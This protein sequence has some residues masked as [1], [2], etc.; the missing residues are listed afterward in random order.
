MLSVK[1]NRRQITD[2]FK[3]VGV[4]VGDLVA[5]QVIIFELSVKCWRIRVA[6]GDRVA[7]QV[8]IFKLSVKCWRIRVAVGDRVA[9]QVIIFELSVKYRRNYAVGINVDDCG[10]SSNYFRT[11][12]EMPTNL[13]RRYG[14]RWWW[15]F[16]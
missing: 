9:F 16:K 5:F 13:F 1:L 8:I 6:V 11:L 3:F 14:C 10:I 2:V 15:H 12:C 4:A 7:F